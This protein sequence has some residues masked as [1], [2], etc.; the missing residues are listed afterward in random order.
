MTRPSFAD[1]IYDFIAVRRQTGHHVA[2][3]RWDLRSFLRFAE[4]AGHTGA[5]TIELAASWAESATSPGVAKRRL[6]FIRQ[7]ARYCAAFDPATQIPPPGMLGG[8]SIWKAPHVYTDDEI[9]ALLRE[10]ALLGRP[11]EPLRAKTLV[12]IF[13]LLAATGLRVSEACRLTRDDVDLE[14]GVLMIRET[15]FRKSRLVPLHPTAVAALAHYAVERDRLRPPSE[16]FFRTDRKGHIVRFVVEATLI[17]L[18]PRLGWTGNGRARLPRVHDLRHT[19]AARCLLRWYREGADIDRKILALATY[20]GHADPSYTYWY[21]SA[22]PELLA[23]TSRR[24]EHFAHSEEEGA[25]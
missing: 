22:V 10:T 15:K 8:T 6:C 3:A 1:R 21:L 2:S 18:R 23:I 13:S 25:V 5:I 7:F 19:F 16:S 9:T 17:Q 11:R 24:F 4:A 12:A 14:Q 20:L